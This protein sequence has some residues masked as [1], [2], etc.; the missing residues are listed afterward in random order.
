M[1]YAAARN[2]P[3]QLPRPYDLVGSGAITVVEVAAI[4]IRD[5]AK[6]DMRVRP[7]INP[8][9]GQQLGW[10]G[11]IEEDERPDHLPLRRRQSAPDLETAEIASS[12]ND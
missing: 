8:L 5:S 12:G 3:V 10:P 4:E 7:N 6:T 11:L 9:T 2:H 1:G